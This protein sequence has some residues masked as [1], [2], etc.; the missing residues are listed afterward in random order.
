MKKN[1]LIG[2][3]VLIGII[4][5]YWGITY[6]KGVN[7]FKPANYFYANFDRVDG[8]NVATPVT[9]NGFQVGQVRNIEYDYAS[10]KI[11]VELNLEKEFKV[12]QGTT[13]TSS[14]ELL[15]GAKL[16]LSLGDSQAFMKPGDKIPTK[17]I[18]GL[19]DKVGSDVIPQVT[20]MLPKL[21]SI[22]TSVN[23]LVANPALTRSVSRLDGI[24]IQ[25]E[26]SAHQLSTLMSNLNKSVPNL[27]SNV[28][29]VTGELK[30][31][32][33]NFSDMS[34]SLKQLPLDATVA[35]LNQTINN[36]KQLSNKLNDNN[37]SLGLLLSDKQ[38]YNNATQAIA[39]LEALL[40]DIKQNP[41]KYITIK[42]F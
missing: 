19:M 22:L 18:S 3:T 24:T 17:R 27:M 20:A 25:L 38:L 14:A 31:T 42:V 26:T 2:L 4:L 34:A 23:T 12:P 11:E 16:E 1:F 39:N 15:G 9:V 5:L 6:L 41:K 10:N 35:N 33:S 30:T 36:L 40:A 32:V 21:D 7:L 13:I 28:N 37:S 29:G 8:I